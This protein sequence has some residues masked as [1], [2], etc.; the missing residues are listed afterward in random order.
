[1]V[2]SPSKRLGQQKVMSIAQERMLRHATR[3]EDGR[4]WNGGNPAGLDPREDGQCCRRSITVVAT[5]TAVALKG[6]EL[7]LHQPNALPQRE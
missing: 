1:M 5:A 2:D 3:N 4:V 7:T 6:R